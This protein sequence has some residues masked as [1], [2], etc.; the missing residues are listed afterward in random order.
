MNSLD[1]T[2][3]QRVSLAKKRKN[4]IGRPSKISEVVIRKLKEAFENDCTI[5]EACRRAK[6]TTVTYY[7]WKKKDQNFSYEM[8]FYEEYLKNISLGTISKWARVNA[9]IAMEVAKARDDRYKPQLAELPQIQLIQIN[10]GV[11]NIQLGNQ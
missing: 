7:D 2:L 8:D 9:H 1:L 3:E 4:K 11:V 6:I 10:Q 5:T